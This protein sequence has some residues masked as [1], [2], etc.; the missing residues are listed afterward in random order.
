MRITQEGLLAWDI[1]LLAA[2]NV[3]PKTWSRRLSEACA[4]AELTSPHVY[5]ERRKRRERYLV[6]Y[7]NISGTTQEVRDDD[8]GSSQHL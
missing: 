2:A 7:T 5:K 8:R 4:M 1:C 3:L 6:S